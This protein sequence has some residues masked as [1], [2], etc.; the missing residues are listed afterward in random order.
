V[1]GQ[2]RGKQITE[3][4]GREWRV[5]NGRGSIDQSKTWRLGPRGRVEDVGCLTGDAGSEWA[6]ARGGELPRGERRAAGREPASV[7]Q[8]AGMR[9]WESARLSGG[10]VCS[11]RAR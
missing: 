11:R 1:S 8:A 4:G 3:E 2:T 10:A 7:H 9:N 5:G 6:S